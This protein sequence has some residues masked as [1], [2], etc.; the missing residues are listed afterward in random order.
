MS[1]LDRGV[2]SNAVHIQDCR[3]WAE[4]HYLDSATDYREY[5][6]QSRVQPGGAR[7]DLV[8]QADSERQPQAKTIDL[9]MLLAGIVLVLASGYLYGTILDLLQR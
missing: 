2:Q 5:L 7:G 1:D 4:I 3:V 6:A 9:S 8:I